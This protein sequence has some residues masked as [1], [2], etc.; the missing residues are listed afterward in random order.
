MRTHGA[1]L[2]LWCSCCDAAAPVSA[3]TPEDGGCA[4]Q[5]PS[6]SAFE[7]DLV[8]V[9]N[10]YRSTGVTCDGAPAPQV[11]PLRVSPTL[12]CA[13]RTHADDMARKG[14]FAHVNP[15]AEDPAARAARL[16]YPGSV[17]ENLAWGQETAEK[18]VSA[19]LA[20][21]GH[22]SNIANP[23]YLAVGSAYVA[24]GYQAP[25]WVQVYGTR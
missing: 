9:V 7:N 19:W 21:P 8:A 24:H 4:A 18:V 5:R 10:R 6:S 13:A 15:G 22:C 20:S 11:T 14:F 3:S 12:D 16:T 23:A 2:L 17:G 1:A 25:I